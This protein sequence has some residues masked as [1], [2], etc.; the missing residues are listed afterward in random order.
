M[1]FLRTDNMYSKS[2]QSLLSQSLLSQSLLSQSL[3]ALVVIRDLENIVSDYTVGSQQYWRREMRGIIHEL[4]HTN[5]TKFLSN[6][7]ETDKIREICRHVLNLVQ[8]RP[9]TANL[10]MIIHK[11][12]FNFLTPNKNT[13]GSYVS[14]TNFIDRSSEN[15]IYTKEDPRTR[16]LTKFVGFSMKN[17]TAVDLSKFFVYKYQ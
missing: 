9:R 13:E 14:H 3:L 15:I 7:P 17:F 12:V 6:D 11:I 10:F 4:E 8:T 5:L 16:I 2:S 1:S